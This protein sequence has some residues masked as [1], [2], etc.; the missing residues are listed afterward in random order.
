MPSN[1]FVDY[2]NS[3][4][5]QASSGNAFCF[6]EARGDATAL[7]RFGL[8]RRDVL[9]RTKLDA[10]AEA[11]S[12][13]EF[14]FRS[15]ILTGDAGDGKTACCERFAEHLAGRQL[16][17][18][19]RT[20]KRLEGPE[21]GEWTILKDG[22]ELSTPDVPRENLETIFSD[23]LGPGKGRFFLAVNEGRLRS[24]ARRVGRDLLWRPVLEPALDARESNTQAVERAE[25][26]M[27]AS[28]VLVVH[29]RDRCTVASQQVFQ[30]VVASLTAPTRWEQRECGACPAATRCHIIENAKALRN[31]EVRASLRRVL[32]AAYD[33]GQALPFRRVQGYVAAL[34]T[35]GHSCVGESSTPAVQSGSYGTDP[36]RALAFRYYNLAFAQGPVGDSVEPEPLA[37]FLQ[38]FDPALISAAECDRLLAGALAPETL[39]ASFRLGICAHER[40]AIG[41][42]AGK[43]EGRAQLVRSLK[44]KASFEGGGAGELGAALGA[45]GSRFFLESF[46]VYDRA[47]TSCPGG[48]ALREATARVVQGLNG[49][50]RRDEGDLSIYQLDPQELSAGSRFG[51]FYQ[52]KS[53]PETSLEP[54][55]PPPPTAAEYLEHRPSAL[56]FRA[57]GG[58]GEVSL[59]VDLPLFELLDSVARGFRVPQA[60][61]TYLHDVQRFKE[62][63]VN[64]FGGPEPK[65]SIRRGTRQLGIRV[66]ESGKLQIDEGGAR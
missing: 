36:E 23:E 37:K 60:F 65:L 61:G 50:D 31:P 20:R 30:D 9:V 62:R 56:V 33:S 7:G 5:T 26:A 4:R 42:L 52:L 64:A 16:T 6:H 55:P 48:R 8:E 15:V 47:I 59:R 27:R 41:A 3:L 35:G 34:I 58:S 11:A 49:L 18:T 17:P 38:R 54:L 13:P 19:E 63:L 28:R 24:A 14:P 66:S 40:A 46:D 43:P 29:L 21:F 12:K 57:R 22:S 39:R 2:L 44:R 32:V 51:L 25:E 45:F 53:V 1:R 10:L